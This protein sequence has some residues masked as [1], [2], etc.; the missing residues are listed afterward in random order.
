MLPLLL[1]RLRRLTPGRLQGIHWTPELFGIL[2]V[3]F[4]Q[5]A[6]GLARLATSFYLKDSLGLSPA[7]VAALTGIAVIPW[8]LKPLYGL[9]SDTLPIVGYRRKPYL[10][11]SGLLGCG[12]WLGMALW[13]PTAGLAT[14]WVE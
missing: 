9:L 14:M 3:Y 12:A 11:L 4:V 5:G 8:T 2:L 1:Q 10:V 13:A 6:V 7:Q